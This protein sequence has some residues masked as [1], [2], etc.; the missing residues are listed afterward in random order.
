LIIHNNAD[1]KKRI[2]AKYVES[3]KNIRRLPESDQSIRRLISYAEVL[4]R[5][6]VTVGR[7]DDDDDDG[8]DDGGGGQMMSGQTGRGFDDNDIMTMMM[9]SVQSVGRW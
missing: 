3:V 5:Y 1:C 2:F 8:D 7:C 4:P 9:I 6:L